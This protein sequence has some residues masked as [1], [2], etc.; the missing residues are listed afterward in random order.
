MNEELKFISNENNQ[1]MKENVILIK[2][3]DFGEPIKLSASILKTTAGHLA[4]VVRSIFHSP[5]LIDN[6]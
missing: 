4:H 3:A 2:P 5:F 6:L 1:I